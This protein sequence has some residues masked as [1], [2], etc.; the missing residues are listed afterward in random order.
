[1]KGP[2]PGARYDGLEAR[3]LSALAAA[4]LEARSTLMAFNPAVIAHIRSLAPRARTTLLVSRGAVERARARPETAVEWGIAAGV[5]DVGLEH[6]L[7]EPAVVAAARAAGLVLG[8]WTVNEE[9]AMRRMLALGVDIL[10]TDR[11][12]TAR[13]LARGEA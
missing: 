5:T 3:I 8:V 11:P 1:V 7:V 6:T 4:G 2:A 12:D 13:R 10:T 9:A